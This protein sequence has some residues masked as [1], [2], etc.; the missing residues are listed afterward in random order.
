MMSGLRKEYDGRE[1]LNRH[2]RLQSSFLIEPPRRFLSKSNSIKVT[3][4]DLWPIAR[5]LSLTRKQLPRYSGGSQRSLFFLQ[6]TQ[7]SFTY[8]ARSNSD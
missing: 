5:M 1:P 4:P 7:C 8:S 6:V 2:A 3:R